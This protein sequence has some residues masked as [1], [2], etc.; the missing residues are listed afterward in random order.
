M[1]CGFLSAFHL[2]AEEA[3]GGLDQLDLHLAGAVR[4]ASVCV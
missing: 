4:L 3:G 1:L 2:S